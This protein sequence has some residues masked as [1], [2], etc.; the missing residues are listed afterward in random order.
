MSLE[1]E[2]KQARKEIVSDGY[3][4]SLGEII[5]LYK[6]EELKINPEFQRRFR[7]DITCQWGQV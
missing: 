6:D 3:D 1:N 4:M 7:W 2:I 5:N